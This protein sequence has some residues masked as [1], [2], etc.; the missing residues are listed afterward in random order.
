LK[1]NNMDPK[2]RCVTDEFSD[3]GDWQMRLQSIRM[4]KNS[5]F[6]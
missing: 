3:V 1:H 6:I 4:I 5:L 2:W